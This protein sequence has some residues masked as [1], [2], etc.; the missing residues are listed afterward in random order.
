MGIKL[1]KL[2]NSCDK[3]NFKLI[4]GEKNINNSVSWIH[5]VEGMEI[6]QFVEP[7]EL[8]FTTGIAIE[9]EEELFELVKSSYYSNATG[10]VINIGP[11]I[12]RI[13]EEIINFCNEHDFPLF[14][15]PWHVHLAEIMR[16]FCYQITLA[17]RVEIELS[18]AIKN[19][20]FFPSQKDSYMPQLERYGFKSENSYC[21]SIIEIFDSNN[22]P[23]IDMEKQLSL[24]KKI[25]NALIFNSNGICS[26][27]IENKFVILFS[28]YEE[29]EVKNVYIQNLK[30]LKENLGINNKF[31]I[32]IGNKVKK[33]EDLGKTYKN[34]LNVL[35]LKKSENFSNED[36][37]LYSDLGL[38]KVILSVEDKQ[39]LK[40]FYDEN[41]KS[42]IKY[43]ELNE[44]DYMKVLE[45]YLRNNGSVKAVSQELFYHKNT[46]CY[47]IN[48]IEEILNIDFSDFKIRANL[49]LSILIKNYI[50]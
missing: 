50:T 39:I 32:S 42:I 11:F 14:E 23:V 5:M 31:F 16:K 1:S 7:N 40:E 43:D 37:V 27:I 30:R 18:S 17:E 46:I 22:L 19:A 41:L 10:F 2:Y 49:Y 38:Y 34:A 47:K 20:L 6:T 3:K 4:A 12:S 29:L 25:E 13:P 24:L 15:M 33:I 28:G 9:N 36:I 8:S 21:I 48:K 35:K 45:S 26:L 44:T